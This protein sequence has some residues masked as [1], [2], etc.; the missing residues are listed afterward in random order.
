[1]GVVGESERADLGLIFIII[2][3]WVIG[4][5]IN[6]RK[7][8]ERREERGDHGGANPVSYLIEVLHGYDGGGVCGGVVVVFHC[9]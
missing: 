3:V 6:T 2:V 9:V 5:D 7:A 1:M 4:S 8:L